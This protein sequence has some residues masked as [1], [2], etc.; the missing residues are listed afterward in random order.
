MLLAAGGVLAASGACELSLRLV[1]HAWPFE[2]EI[3]LP[4]YLE[5]REQVLRWRFPADGVGRNS[6]GLRN[7]EIGPKP[8]G[9]R[10]ILVLGDS[11][12][13]SGETTSGELYTQVVE[14][15]LN[16]RAGNAGAFEVINAGVPGYTTF[17]ERAFLDLHGLGMAPDVV[18]LGFVLNDLYYPYLHRPTENDLLDLEPEA[19]L[20]RFDGTSGAGRLFARSYLAHE[21]V[22][23]VELLAQRFRGVV[24]E[25]RHYPD[26]YLAWERHPWPRLARLSRDLADDL[27]R[28]GIAFGIV[29]FPVR[30]Q[31]DPRS[32]GRRDDELLFPQVRLRGICEALG[33]PLWDTTEVLFANGGPKLFRDYLHLAPPGN[34]VVARGLE[35]FLTATWPSITQVHPE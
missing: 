21:A 10:R 5:A 19:A 9:V 28:R 33:V 8:P 27:R 11:L 4:P 24:F 15:R 7:R 14:R 29:A 13:F 22:A 20:G 18:V 25:F 3:R 32:R 35:E 12:V 31:V 17:Q 30:E 23:G 6:L 2:R 34:D 26:F 1:Y 16:E